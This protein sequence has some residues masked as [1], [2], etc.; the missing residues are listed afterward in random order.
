LQPDQI[1]LIAIELTYDSVDF[2]KKFLSSLPHLR[3]T[4]EKVLSHCC[5][6]LIKALR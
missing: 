2:T 3:I 6:G 5:S 1:I 4:F